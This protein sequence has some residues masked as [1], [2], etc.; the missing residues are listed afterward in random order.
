MANPLQERQLTVTG[1]ST[2]IMNSIQHTGL[3]HRM[4][5]QRAPRGHSRTPK[6]ELQNRLRGLHR[7]EKETIITDKTGVDAL[8][9]AT[10][11]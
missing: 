1:I 6:S 3:I 8:K 5:T 9:V 4:Q 11:A 10:A 2:A 7:R